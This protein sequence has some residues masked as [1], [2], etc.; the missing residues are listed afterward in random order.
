MKAREVFQAEMWGRCVHCRECF[1]V[2]AA[3]IPIAEDAIKPLLPIMTA[4]L[5]AWVELHDCEASRAYRERN[6]SAT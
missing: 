2:A 4:R 6:A 1:Q 5:R 3:T